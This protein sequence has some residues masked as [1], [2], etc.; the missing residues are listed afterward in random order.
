LVAH[1]LGLCATLKALAARYHTPQQLVVVINTTREEEHNLLHALAVVR[2]SPPMIITNE[3]TAQDR[4]DLYLAGGVL[5]VTARI[6]VV[7]LLCNRVPTEQATGLI[8]ANAHNVTEGSNLAFIVRIFRQR[9]QVGFIKALSDHA[10]G[11]TSG[12][13]RAEK[14]MRLLRVRRLKL[15]PRFHLEVNHALD[16]CQPI[17]DE[18]RV[19]LSTR[20]AMLQR[21]LLQAVDECLQE[22][23]SLN[24]SVDVSQFTVEKSILKSFDRIVRMQ[25]EPI[26]HRTNRRTRALVADLQTLRKLLAFLISCDCVSFFEY[27]ETVVDAASALHPAERPH[28]ILNCSETVFLIAR[29]RV[30][31]L[32]RTQQVLMPHEEPDLESEAD[33]E[34]KDASG[35]EA[36]TK[37]QRLAG[38]DDG[39]TAKL[40][41]VAS[42][43]A[44]VGDAAP[45][46][47]VSP[48][49]A[50]GIGVAQAP[51]L[52]VRCVL[53]PSPKWAAL[54]DILTEI[55]TVREAGTR[56]G[57]LLVVRDERTG[58]TIR[59]LVAHG[60]KPLLE[61]T[62]VRWVARRR[63]SQVAARTIL[64]ARQ[65]EARLLRVA[66]DKLA[67]HRSQ[68][69][70]QPPTFMAVELYEAPGG[71]RGRGDDYRG[72]RR[73]GRGNSHG[74]AGR[75]GGRCCGSSSGGTGV[76]ICFGGAG[77]M[78]HGSAVPRVPAPTLG[79]ATSLAAHFELLADVEDSMIV[80]THDAIA[81]EVLEELQP[82]YVVLFDPEPNFVRAIEVAQ[83]TRPSLQMHVYFMMQQDSVE[84]QRYRSALRNE[85]EAFQ[86][87]IN[88]K[89]RMVVPEA[90]VAPVKPPGPEEGALVAYDDDDRSFC[91]T[92]SS[93]R[94]VARSVA[95]SPL[96]GPVV[97][98]DVREFRSA[99]PSMLH[100]NGM[101]V[102]PVTLE[103]GDYV[104]SPEVCVERKAITDLIQSLSSGRL[105]NQAEAML[106]YY[107]RP[108][109]LIECEEGR[110]FGLVNPNE[111]GPDISTQSVL[112]KLSLMLLHF[113]K[114][115]L[116]WSR[117]AVH[118]VAIF[119]ALKQGQPEPDVATAASVGMNTAPFARSS[120][121][122]APQAVLRQLPGVHVHNCRKLMNSVMNLQELA[123]KSHD[124]LANIIG[125][126]N[127]R[128]LFEFL[129]R[130]A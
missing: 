33:A 98:V 68:E 78:A 53:E 37:R 128:L 45:V 50:A 22:L 93:R 43:T 102:R 99:L 64:S 32:Q 47:G 9:N 15:W 59:D 61:A 101:E 69:P 75:G 125:P 19:A 54:R 5:L 57:C 31:E 118:T 27:L 56:G 58:A 107:R 106:R 130:E 4:V 51:P 119:T 82:R 92:Q 97:I 14:T 117:S 72:N 2:K 18:V 13:A 71:D 90:Y 60:A 110:P 12:F 30:Y 109:L 88:E 76:N 7:D 63:R 34:A 77:E 123:M 62:F 35:A 65:H 103:V 39:S 81:S 122:M 84:E 89:G 40:M 20:G 10:G 120:F 104:L 74:G 41:N 80:C 86:V 55:K 79:G 8:I 48:S 1:G 111:L 73:Q 36:P 127:G 126:Q 70:A 25:L 116:L 49:V 6:F 52:N 23:R 16:T 129:H 121:N 17:V 21:A 26:W 114:L 105:F 83:A 3:C 46:L 113:P 42:E 87:L 85:R 94:P 124:E 24:Q 11:V 96:R 66:A 67:A 44:A 100:L 28:W 38:C 115:R 91:R 112:S 29:D 95:V 108:A